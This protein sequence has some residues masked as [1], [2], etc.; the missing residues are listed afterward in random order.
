MISRLSRADFRRHFL[1]NHLAPYLPTDLIVFAAFAISLSAECCSGLKRNRGKPEINELLCCAES[2]YRH[3]PPT[4]KWMRWWESWIEVHAPGWPTQEVVHRSHKIVS[5][6]GWLEW[7][8][9]RNEIVIHAVCVVTVSKRF[10]AMTC[11]PLTINCCWDFQRHLFAEKISNCLHLVS[12][13]D[14]M[15][16]NEDL[17]YISF[18]LLEM[19]QTKQNKNSCQVL[20]EHLIGKVRLNHRLEWIRRG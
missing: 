5:Q 2:R 11:F 1:I 14:W 6:L 15:K 18:L 13:H 16:F 20:T 4:R 9:R 19:K 10:F 8:S 3:R 7:W 17:W 12:L